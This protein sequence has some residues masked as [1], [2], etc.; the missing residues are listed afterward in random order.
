MKKTALI[1]S[2][3][4]TVTTFSQNYFGLSGRIGAYNVTGGVAKTNF[5]LNTGVGLD[6]LHQFDNWLRLSISAYYAP[7][8]YKEQVYLTNSLGQPISE[9]N[10]NYS[11]KYVSLPVLVGYTFPLEKMNFY[12]NI[13]VV[14]AYLLGVNSKLNGNTIMQDIASYNQIDISAILNFGTEFK[15]GEKLMLNTDLNLT[16]GFLSVSDAIYSPVKNSK[17][18]GAFIALGLKYKL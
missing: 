9:T 6:F 3:C 14:P 2:L 5:A 15:L 4:F 18:L 8:A 17:R 10:I 13:G 11:L 12:G 1:I 7:T 16:K